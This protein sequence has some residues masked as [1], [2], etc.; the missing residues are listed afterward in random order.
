M[1]EYCMNQAQNILNNR[2][3][4][5]VKKSPQLRA[6]IP[7][8]A[9]IP[10]YFF[11]LLSDLPTAIRTGNTLAVVGSL[12]VIVTVSGT[13]VFAVVRCLF[14]LRIERRRQ[15]AARGDARFLAEMQ[16]AEN[17]DAVKPPFTITLRTNWRSYFTF[18]GI[19]TLIVVVLVIV[20]AASDVFFLHATLPVFIG[21]ILV[22]VAG[23]DC[24][25]HSLD[26]AA[27][28]K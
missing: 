2:Q 3:E 7:L 8:F 27:D 11:Y 26:L 17:I 20:F 22:V 24:A 18:V 12:V 10:I 14:L 21:I 15:V 9:F 5:V 23:F 1:D 19:A 13:L 4:D 25:G 6:I 16:P 28:I